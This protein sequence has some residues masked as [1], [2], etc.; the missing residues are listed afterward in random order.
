MKIWSKKMPYN[1]EKKLDIHNTYYY[2][3][4][5]KFFCQYFQG[6]SSKSREK[7]VQFIVKAELNQIK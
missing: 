6:R 4:R 2:K 1:S 3:R 5:K 7:V